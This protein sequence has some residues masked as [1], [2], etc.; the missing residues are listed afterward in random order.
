M[1][2]PVSALVPPLI[3]RSILGQL[4][5]Q[6]MGRH[7]PEEIYQM[8][9]TDLSAVAAFLGHKPFF[10]GETPTG[11]DAVAYGFLAN[12]LRVKLD[13]PLLRCALAFPAL[14]DFCK[15]MEARYWT[16]R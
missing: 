13:T 1:P 5:G 15:R 3:R 4:H 7:R 12:I 9:V 11:L 2:W 10:M 14:S 8:G 6:G 16:D